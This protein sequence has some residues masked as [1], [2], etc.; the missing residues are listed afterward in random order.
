MDKGCGCPDGDEQ[1]A[2]RMRG[3]RGGAMERVKS[4]DGTTIAYDRSGRGA[5]LALVVGSFGA[6]QVVGGKGSGRPGSPSM[7]TATCSLLAK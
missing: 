7:L 2:T 3:L 4:A 5:A 1:I 6:A